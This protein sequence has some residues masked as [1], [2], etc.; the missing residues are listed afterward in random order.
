M[1]LQPSSRCR[2]HVAGDCGS[3]AANLGVTLDFAHSL[4]ADEQ[5]AFAAA[6]IARES[7]LLGLHLNDG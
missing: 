2:N 5:P 1:G 6:L 3:G 7:R 4:Y